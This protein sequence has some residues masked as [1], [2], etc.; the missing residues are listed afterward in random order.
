MVT[1]ADLLKKQQ[2]EFDTL[3]N[4]I[5]EF[6][7]KNDYSYVWSF[8]KYHPEVDNTLIMGDW[9]CHEDCGLHALFRKLIQGGEP[10]QACFA[11]ILESGKEFCDAMSH[12]DDEKH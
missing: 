12:P 1:T 2:A 11:A 8:G 7:K 10:A 4:Q 3:N 9:H 5:K 6:C